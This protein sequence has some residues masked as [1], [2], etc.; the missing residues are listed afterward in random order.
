MIDIVERLDALS[1]NLSQVSG[2]C[3][4]VVTAGDRI[5][6]ALS[7]PFRPSTFQ[8]VRDSWNDVSDKRATVEEG[9]AELIRLR[10]LL[11]EA[12]ECLDEFCNLTVNRDYDE[13]CCQKARSILSCI[14][15]E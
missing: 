6:E 8:D 9:K 12:G 15:G 1:K 2:S 5:Q 4:S 10:S 7:L 14:K 3:L 11:K 13:D